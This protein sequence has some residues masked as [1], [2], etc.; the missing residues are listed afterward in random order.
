M[1][2]YQYRCSECS[3]EFEVF[4]PISKI[5]TPTKEQC[6]N[7]SKIAVERQFSGSPGICYKPFWSSVQSHAPTPVK[8]R[9]QQIK[10]KYGGRQGYCKGIE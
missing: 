2:T 5:E 1:P 7:C 4:L 3:H 8:E 6:P 9:L 10:Q